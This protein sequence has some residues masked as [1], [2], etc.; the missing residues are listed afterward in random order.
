LTSLSAQGHDSETW[1]S[2]HPEAERIGTE[3]SATT[4]HGPDEPEIMG[5][6]V[7]DLANFVTGRML[8]F[9]EE[10]CVHG[11]ENTEL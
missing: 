2:L 3:M 9:A 10:I 5:Q 6:P 4:D 7:S 8:C 1:D 11:L